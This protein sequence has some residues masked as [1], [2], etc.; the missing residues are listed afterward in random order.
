MNRTFFFF[1]DFCPSYGWKYLLP[2][3]LQVLK[4]PVRFSR[5]GGENLKIVRNEIKERR[6]EKL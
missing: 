6:N 5:I 2:L 3:V 4:F 1:Y